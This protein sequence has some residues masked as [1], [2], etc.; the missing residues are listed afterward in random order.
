MELKIAK[1]ILLACK[2]ELK[3]A[4]ND[5]LNAKKTISK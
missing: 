3:P 4:I 1:N 2:N 5:A